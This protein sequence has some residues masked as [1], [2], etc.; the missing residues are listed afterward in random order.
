M[1]NAIDKEI[2]IKI[3]N[4]DINVWR[5]VKAVQIAQY[6]FKIT[7]TTKFG[8]ELDEILEFKQGDIVKCKEKRRRFLCF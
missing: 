5:L 6:I 2:F 8:S 1:A 3:L 7:N 4:E